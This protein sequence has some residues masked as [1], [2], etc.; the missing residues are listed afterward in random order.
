LDA[1]P[2]KDGRYRERDYHYL[3][4]LVAQDGRILHLYE[5]NDDEVFYEK[6]QMILDAV[7]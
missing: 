6:R 4:E 2:L 3:N 7:L 1:K 5:T